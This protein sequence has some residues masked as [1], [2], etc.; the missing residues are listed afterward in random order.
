MMEDS[1][2]VM[3]VPMHFTTSVDLSSQELPDSKLQSRNSASDQLNISYDKEATLHTLIIRERPF[4]TLQCYI[5]ASPIST[6]Y[7]KG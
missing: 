2:V 5:G 7:L 6:K 3:A 1:F 4:W